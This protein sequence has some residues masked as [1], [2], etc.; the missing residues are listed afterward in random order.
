MQET[1]TAHGLGRRVGALVLVLG[2]GLPADSATAQQ[3][4]ADK[5]TGSAVGGTLTLGGNNQS[6]T[7]SERYNVEPTRIAEPPRLD[8]VLDEEMW[9][10][11]AVIDQFVQQE[12]AEGDPATERTI[13]RL[14]YDERALYIGVEA[15]DSIPGGVIATE[16]RRDSR[17]L[18]DEDNFQLIL[19]T[20][21]DS[22]SGYMFVTSPLGAKLEQQVSE[23]GE[24]GFRGNSSNINVDWDGVWDVSARRT[25]QGWVA[26]IAIPMVT[27]RFPEADRQVWGVNFMRNI[28]R[29]N[30]Q[31]Y[32]APIEKGYSLTRVSLAG[33]LTGL[34]GVD[35]GM[36]LRVTPYVLSGDGRTAARPPH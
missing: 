31:V 6:L 24:G 11:A 29:K 23:E 13:V 5:Q 7:P 32:W 8:G 36:D 22:R 9:L 25:D 16:M 14:M 15:Y 2:L 12:P 20:F 26:E 18:L 27:L 35:R 28:R 21:H 3:A 34:G 33:T 10:A 19:D 1:S 30:E 17:Q 4:G